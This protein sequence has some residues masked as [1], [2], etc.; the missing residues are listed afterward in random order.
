MSVHNVLYLCKSCNAFYDGFAQCCMELNHIAY[1]VD[2]NNQIIKVFESET[3]DFESYNESD[4]ESENENSCESNS[5]SEIIFV[6][7][8]LEENNTFK[9]Y[10]EKDLSSSQKYFHDKS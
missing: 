1:E 5:S 4:N 8:L 2:E 6:N 3:T 7:D 9:I 10:Y